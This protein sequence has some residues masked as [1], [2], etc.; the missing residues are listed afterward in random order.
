VACRPALRIWAVSEIGD[1]DGGQK[2]KRTRMYTR[3]EACSMVETAKW[4]D[5]VPV[6]VK[7]IVAMSWCWIWLLV[8]G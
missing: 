6:V 3:G 2:Q 4:S 8:A 7:G 5:V 1:V